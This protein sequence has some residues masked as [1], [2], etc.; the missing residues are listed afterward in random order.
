M[1]LDSVIM[2]SFLLF[3]WLLAYFLRINEEHFQ[4]D[5]FETHEFA[6]EFRNLPRLSEEFSAEMLKAELAQVI[7]EALANEEQVIDRLAEEDEDADQMRAEKQACEVV[8]IQFGLTSYKHMYHTVKIYDITQKVQHLDLKIRLYDSKS[9]LAKLQ[10]EKEELLSAVEFHTK[11]YEQEKKSEEGDEEEDTTPQAEVAFVLFRSM[12][13]VERA[14][15][16]F[17]TPWYTRLLYFFCRCC[18]SEEF[19]AKILHGRF[20]RA[21]RTIEPELINWHN[22]GVTRNQKCLTTSTFAG[23]AVMVLLVS[24]YAIQITTNGIRQT[25][26]T[27]P[28]I[29]CPAQVSLDAA[30]FDYFTDVEQQNGD[31]HCF[32]LNLLKEEG[33]QA[34]RTAV[35]TV[36]GEAH[37]SEWLAS[38]QLIFYLTLL[39][40]GIIAVV[41]IAIEHLIQVTEEQR[42]PVD[43]TE[44]ALQAVTGIKSVQFVNLGLVLV[45]VSIHFRLSDDDVFPRVPGA[46][47]GDFHEFTAHWYQL[48]SPQIVCAMVFQ[49][50]VPHVVPFL[51]LV[52]QHV[53]RCWD[54]RCTCDPRKTKKRIQ[55]DYEALYIG[56]EF[57]LDSRLAQV[58][59]AVWVTFFFT[60]GIPLLLPVMIVN[61]FVMYCVDKWMLLRYYRTPKN[62]DASIIN[63]L[64]S[65]LKFAFVIH[66]IFGT[67]M[68]SNE[69]LFREGPDLQDPGM[70]AGGPGVLGGE[71]AMLELPEEAEFA[72][73]TF[74]L[75]SRYTQPHMIAFFAVSAT[76]FLLILFENMLH[77]CCSKTRCFRALFRQK[78]ESMDA[79]S[80]DF[81][82]E[83]TPGGLI[84]EHER[85][86]AA[87]QEY[88]HFIARH[89][90]LEYFEDHR[91]VVCGFLNKL[92]DKEILL[93]SKIKTYCRQMG[94]GGASAEER[95]EL[96]TAHSAATMRKMQL[97]MR[98]V[99]QS[100]DM[101]DQQ[102]YAGVR[103]IQELVDEH[104]GECEL[105]GR[106][107]YEQ[108]REAFREI[109]EEQARLD[110]GE[111]TRKDTE[112]EN[113]LLDPNEAPAGIGLEELSEA[114]RASASLPE[115]P[116]EDVRPSNP[117]QPPAGYG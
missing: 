18:F 98:S 91:Q 86:K 8:D 99:L 10:A 104:E 84:K 60:P 97:R 30:Q 51:Q 26:R 44:N 115:Q 28:D 29:A 15:K 17:N 36:D 41:S 27:V 107:L 73:G 79:V 101:N 61:F 35:F 70:Q 4:R 57:T 1:A 38:H 19:K 49:I 77:S 72:G 75:D 23:A 40:P 92:V 39:I 42:R 76:I 102:E 3:V 32:C 114:D 71:S 108:L 56:P 80:S 103:K 69:Q 106:E 9:K 100:Y 88:V 65:Q 105:S 93:A 47:E 6:L 48:M 52:V 113:S 22:F 54:R 109:V 83:L 111:E 64:I 55:S 43:E 87:K 116:V 16:A 46:L 82:A 81:Y 67:C 58:I 12:E 37:C 50:A 89:Q 31:F 68:L 7:E 62:Y 110:E 24:F 85:T 66:F 63:Y 45:F 74:L 117:A 53:R 20:L 78:Y 2:V 94:L 25:M 34:A 33:L 59:A 14:L 11:I 90:H 95:N 112:S 5:F 21:R 96:L 13:G